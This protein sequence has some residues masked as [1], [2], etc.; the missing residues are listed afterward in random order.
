MSHKTAV[1]SQPATDRSIEAVSRVVENLS[2][3]LQPHELME[4]LAQALVDHFGAVLGEIWLRDEE[5]QGLEERIAR[6]AE[7]ELPPADPA[8]TARLG[9]LEAPLAGAVEQVFPDAGN[10]LPWARAHSA[11]YVLAH[12]LVAHDRHVGVLAVYA[13]SEFPPAALSWAR[14][15]AGIAAVT[16]DDAWVLAENRKAITQLQFLV[17]ASQVLNSTLDLAEL[18]ALILKLALREIGADRGS[19]YMVDQ[20]RREIWTTLAEGLALPALR[21]GAAGLEQQ[22]IRLAFGRGV[23]GYVAETGR[24]LNVA[25]AYSCPQFDRS[26]DERLNYRTRTLLCM[27]IRNRNGDTVGVLQLIN[28]LTGQFIKEDEE[29]LNTLSVHM[30]LALENARLHR[31]LLEKQR[32][33]RELQLARGIQ[34][35]LLPDSPPFVPGYDL[36]VLNEPC[37]EVG[38]DYYDFLALGPN[39]LLVVV[40]DVEGKG[41]SSAMI[42]SNLQAT[43]RALVMHLHSLEVITLSLNEMI[44]ADTRSEKFLSC[45]LGLIDTRRH[46][47][48]YIN[49]GHIPPVVVRRSG[50]VIPLEEGGMVIGLFN[51]VQYERGSLELMPGDI[52]LCCTDG[53]IEACNKEHQE[54]GCERLV[55]LVQR[56]AH[57]S[58]RE[59]VEL[60][61]REVTEFSKGGGHVDDKV[62]VVVK[63]LEELDP[64]AKADPVP[65]ADRTV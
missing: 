43:L 37:Y 26:F 33:E 29:F 7:P 27:P 1:P 58:A 35:S 48:H 14:L 47:L 11:H 10:F 60:V 25:D 50:E 59:L 18:L 28:K 45:F 6:T 5:G 51:T 13:E 63:V 24:V 55:E 19:V 46:G 40:A 16:L 2:S 34:R 21:A 41:V 62:L 38:G 20:E 52:M 3:V 30:A 23:A 54:F 36:A 8:L 42:M 53:I 9:A 64:L 4:P 65:K 61:G 32:L 39:T 17:E 44:L 22:E 57:L 15:Y 31:E 49:A 56:N 12:P